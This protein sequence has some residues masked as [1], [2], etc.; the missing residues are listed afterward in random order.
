M[1]VSVLLCL[2]LSGVCARV[3][4]LVIAASAH[5][6]MEEW[7]AGSVFPGIHIHIINSSFHLIEGQ[8]KSKKSWSRNLMLDGRVYCMV[9]ARWPKPQT[10]FKT[11]AS[12]L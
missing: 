5:S 7:L 2:V 3:L 12:E 10:T 1:A 6:E 11:T 4:E 8:S 9:L